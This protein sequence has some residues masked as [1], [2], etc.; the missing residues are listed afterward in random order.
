MAGPKKVQECP[1]C[2]RATHLKLRKRWECMACGKRHYVST[3]DET[4]VAE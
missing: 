4:E 1:K 2:G 3:T